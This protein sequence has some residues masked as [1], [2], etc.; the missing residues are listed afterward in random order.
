MFNKYLAKSKKMKY[1]KAI[2]K[3]FVSKVVVLLFLIKFLCKCVESFRF[4]S[5]KWTTLSI[6]LRIWWVVRTLLKRVY[7]DC[8]GGIIPFHPKRGCPGYD[9][10]L[11]LMVRFQFWSSR[12]C[13]VLLQ[14]PYSHVHWPEEVVPVRVPSIG[15]INLFKNY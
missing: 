13:G 14:C 9:T 12:V 10:K 7:T 6:G 8:R 5:G 11:H 2:F 15:Q 3:D 4:N 1:C